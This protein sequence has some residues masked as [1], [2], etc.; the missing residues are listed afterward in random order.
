MHL[1]NAGATTQQGFTRF[2]TK[3]FVIVLKAFIS[4]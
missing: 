2:N 1:Y 3:A 4:E